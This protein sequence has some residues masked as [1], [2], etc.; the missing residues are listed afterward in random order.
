MNVLDLERLAQN[1]KKVMESQDINRVRD[2]PGFPFS[3]LDEVRAA[4]A[5]GLITFGARYQPGLIEAW[6]TRGDLIAHYFWLTWPPLI[7]IVF[8]VGAFV[9][10]RYVLLRGVFATSIGFLASSPA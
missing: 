5:S 10:G 6:G 7:G 3:S 8:V 1:E 4:K 2:I 9:T